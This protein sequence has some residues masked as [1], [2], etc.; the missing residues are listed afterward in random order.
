MEKV[1]YGFCRSPFGKMVLGK[2]DHGLCWLGFMVD[3]R[4]GDGYERMKSHFPNAKFVHDD[5]AVRNLGY[6][7]IKAWES[8]EP[9]NILLDLRG[10]GFQ[11]SVWQALLEIKKGEVKS[12]SDIAHDIGNRAAVR[13][14]GSAVGS[15]PV[16][17][18]VPCHRVLQKS[19]AIGNYGWGVSL[20]RKILLA[21][22]LKI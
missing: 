9:D 6:Q 19:G 13:A 22:G 2:T 4:K 3:G 12:Y 7:V 14:V 16:S 1:I 10:S 11:K 15:N 18:I 20:K 8:G 21:E 5:V 17:L